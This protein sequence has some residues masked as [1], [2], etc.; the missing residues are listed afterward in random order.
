M[1][2]VV[3]LG[4]Q[5]SPQTALEPSGTPKTET[6]TLSQMSVCPQRIAICSGHRSTAVLDLGSQGPWKIPDYVG[7]FTG[8]P[9]RRPPALSM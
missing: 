7:M 5:L 4:L 1:V 3:H 9:G 6:H 8:V 2:G